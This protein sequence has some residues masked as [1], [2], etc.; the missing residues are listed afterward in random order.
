MGISEDKRLSECCLTPS[1]QLD[2]YIMTHFDDMLM[3][4]VL[5]STSTL[6]CIFVARAY[7]N[8]SMSL[9]SDIYC[10][11]RANQSMFLLLGSAGLVEKQQ[12]QFHSLWVDQISDQIYDSQHSR[13]GPH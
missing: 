4:P 6:N 3:M 13:R 12:Y 9:H 2:N 5:Y 8:N 10:R 1:D 11:F 7:L